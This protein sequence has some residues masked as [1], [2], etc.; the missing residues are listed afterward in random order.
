MTMTVENIPA[1]AA[2]PLEQASQTHCLDLESVLARA[3]ELR[4]MTL[5]CPIDDDA[6]TQAKAV[7]RA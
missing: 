2:E 7:D 5:A 3:R 6:F 1:A 4:E